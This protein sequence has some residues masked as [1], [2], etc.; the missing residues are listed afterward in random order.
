MAKAD[1]VTPN[2]KADAVCKAVKG[3]DKVRG[4]QRLSILQ[5]PSPV[6]GGFEVW[7]QLY[8]G[9]VEVPMDQHRVFI[10]P[11]TKVVI[12]DKV[13]L[14]AETGEFEERVVREDPAEAFWTILWDSVLTT[15]N[16]SARGRR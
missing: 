5:G 16:A 10:N 12:K 2:T 3:G 15:P 13:I 14:D 1:E 4:K 6:E 7:A 9:D 11:P 8:E